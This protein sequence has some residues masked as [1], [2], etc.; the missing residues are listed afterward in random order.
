[1]DA[2]VQ[3]QALHTRKALMERMAALLGMD[4]AAKFEVSGP[5]GGAIQVT[6]DSLM[7]RTK[8]LLGKF[9]GDLVEAVKTRELKELE[10]PPQVEGNGHTT[11]GHT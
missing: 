3:L 1:M 10:S 5:D 4:A 7:D 6:V 9:G 11:N 8:D 2:R